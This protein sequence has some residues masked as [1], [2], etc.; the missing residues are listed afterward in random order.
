VNEKKGLNLENLTY[1]DASQVPARAKRYTPYREL[2]K[3]VR[4]GKAVV[5]SEDE[6]N[7]DTTRAGVRRLQQKGEFKKIELIQRT[8]PDGKRVLYIVNP[9]DEETEK[10]AS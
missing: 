7:I 8:K 10:K 5:I 2:L 4:K 1:I 6:A 3:R 9:I